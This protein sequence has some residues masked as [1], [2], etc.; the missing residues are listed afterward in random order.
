MSGGRAMTM[1]EMFNRAMQMS[2]RAAT[3]EQEQCGGRE[4]SLGTLLRSASCPGRRKPVSHL[5]R[6]RIRISIPHWRSLVSPRLV[7]AVVGFAMTGLSCAAAGPELAT[8]RKCG[9]GDIIFATRK[10][11]PDGHWYANFG[12]WS[13]NPKRTL[14]HD[15]G[16]LRRLSL[17]SGTVTTLVDEPTGGVRDPQVHYD[18]K[19]ILF[20]CRKGGQPFYH[21]YEINADGTGLRQL[22]DG[23]YD[24]IEP[25]YL[26]DGDIIFCSSRCNRMVNCWFVRVAVIYRC[27]G[28]GRNIRQLSANL[29]Q[30]N[31]PWVLP[32]GKVL[33]QRW[34]YIDRSR[35]NY[36]HLWTMN[37]DGTAQTVYYGNQAPGGVFLD[38]KPI[39]GTD[40]VVM[41]HSPGHGQKE[42]AGYVT[43]V[44]P[45]N[46]P[47]DPAAA[48]RLSPGKHFRD[49]FPLSEDLFILAE[50][51]RMVLM[52]G[53][54][55]TNAVYDLP[56][57]DRTAGFWLHEP[58]PLLAHARER[59]I[60]PSVDP[61]KPT[62]RVVVTNV[63][64]GRNM[65]GV[66]PGEIKKLLV[67]E[68]MPKPVNF[69]GGM[70]PL[71]LG[72]SFTLERIVGTVPVEADGSAYMELP[73]LR[74]LF[75]VALDKD[76]LAV[77]RM[78][79]FMTVEPGETTSCIGCHEKRT[80]SRSPSTNLAATRRAPSRP[81]PVAG[82]P[83]VFDF[84]RDIQP[85]LDRHCV[86]C[87]DCDRTAKGG[88]CAG[89]VIL[90]GDRGPMYSMSYATLTLRRQ[91]SDGRDLAKS[92]Y[93]PRTLGSSASPLL[94]KLDG[95]HYGVTVSAHEK[96]M[97]RLWI[98]TAAPYPGTYA[99]LGSGMVGVGNA[100]VWD[101]RCAGCHQ[102]ERKKHNVLLHHAC[103]LSR[104]EKSLAL[105]APLAK[106]A[107]GYGL[108]KPDV[109]AANTDEDYVALLGAIRQAAAKLNE[110][111]RFD[112]PGFRPNEHYIREMKFYGVLPKDLGDADPVDVYQIDRAYWRSLGW[113]PPKL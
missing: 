51:T 1:A 99:A 5:R 95:S 96:A 111:K 58:R 13:D 101:R 103:N 112:M 62:G 41:I 97:I 31:T 10:L 14:Y 34:E 68:A 50:E 43:V 46:G 75:F 88:P 70:E 86:A 16:K 98:E 40:K 102:G 82:V 77:K 42:H 2:T 8:L 110:I 105:L 59:I 39:P 45:R 92:N 72:G 38:A 22:T 19:R 7:A 12:Y 64:E 91:F 56:E 9:V 67:L 79:S 3:T 53:A 90:N 66:K 37:P 28:D 24:D 107:G 33:Y 81:E 25:C 106:E 76:D 78:Q 74:S 71:T 6:F 30:D 100:A 27:D 108:C 21:L 11:D 61:Q 18:G 20:S 32:Y 4:C 26:P 93:A 84:P 35:V 87:H 83:D 15:G 17:A 44:D 85:I 94:K 49:P 47:D 29:E 60:A 109:F 55:Q 52:D 65:A 69:S 89:G 73:A 36:H 113:Q 48:Q 54:G 104:P 63:Y 57:Q 80:Q 23:D